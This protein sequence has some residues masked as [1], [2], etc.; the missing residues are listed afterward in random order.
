[1]FSWLSESLLSPQ[2]GRGGE[3]SEDITGGPHHPAL[4]AH[5]PL[6]SVFHPLGLGHGRPG[7]EGLGRGGQEFCAEPSARTQCTRN[8]EKKMVKDTF[9]PRREK[10]LWNE[11]N[12]PPEIDQTSK[13]G[14]GQDHSRAWSR[15]PRHSSGR[16][17]T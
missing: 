15:G 13:R 11:R 3:N 7:S 9:Q 8:W 16:A 12:P 14:T 2:A 1:M 6:P 5:T 17:G 10:L 4:G